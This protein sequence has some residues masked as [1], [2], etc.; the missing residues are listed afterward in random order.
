VVTNLQG[1]LTAGHIVNPASVAT[2]TSVVTD[3]NAL[4]DAMAP[5]TPLASGTAPAASETAPA[6]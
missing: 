2:V 5:P 3:L 1:L 4:T 6:A